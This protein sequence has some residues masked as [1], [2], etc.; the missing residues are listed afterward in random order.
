[1]ATPANPRQVTFSLSEDGEHVEVWHNCL[2]ER[3]ADR[4]YAM[5]PLGA[6][7]W[8]VEQREPL[9]VRPSILCHECQCHGW[10][11]EGQWWEA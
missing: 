4:A 9:T 5:L 2:P 3:H 1:M 6:N 10:I 7:G 11:T 8:T